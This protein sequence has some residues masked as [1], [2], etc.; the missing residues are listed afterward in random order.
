MLIAVKHKNIFMKTFTL[1]VFT[2]ITFISGFSQT[3]IAN[4]LEIF[5]EDGEKFTLF[6]NGEKMNDTLQSRVKIENTHH[7]YAK[8]KIEM[9]NPN[10]EPIVKSIVIR[11][12]SE[13]SKMYPT[14]TVF[15]II[16]KKG[17]YKLK[18]VSRSNKKIQMNNAV[19]IHTAY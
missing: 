19:I 18:V 14:T 2:L 10:V 15:N 5:S 4:D 13:E 3:Q 17:K 11:Y 9:D 1:L 6:V 16:K 7:D 8:V 12:N